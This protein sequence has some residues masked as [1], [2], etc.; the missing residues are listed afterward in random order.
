LSGEALRRILITG[1]TGQIGS[2][3]TIE[4]RKRFG[5]E[6]VIATGHKKAIGRVLTSGPFEFSSGQ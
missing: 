5:G 6:N 3:L 1:S 2:E 4:L